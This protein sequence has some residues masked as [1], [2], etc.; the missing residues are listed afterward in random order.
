ME[1]LLLAAFLCLPLVLLV[2]VVAARRAIAI[3]AANIGF[4]VGI[5][6]LL[7][8]AAPARQPGESDE[9][10]AVTAYVEIIGHIIAQGYGWT[11]VV[12]FGL[13]LAILIRRRGFPPLDTEH[14]S[15]H[16]QHD[17]PRADV[18]DNL[19]H[20]HYPTNRG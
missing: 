13:A 12:I 9:S 10:A 5:V 18:V 16:A 20:K 14:H 8:T 15:L 4:V 2:V 1:R 17:L 11:L 6:V 7:G 19:P 3:A